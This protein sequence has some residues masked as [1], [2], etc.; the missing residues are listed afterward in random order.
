MSISVLSV[1]LSRTRDR[2]NA[3]LEK[4]AVSFATCLVCG[5]PTFNLHSTA[6]NNGQE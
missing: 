6:E 2:S 3:N 1:L 4:H 5:F